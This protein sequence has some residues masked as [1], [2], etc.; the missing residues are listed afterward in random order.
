MRIRAGKV[1]VAIPESQ[2]EFLGFLRWSA[3]AGASVYSLTT[4]GAGRGGEM[5]YQNPSPAALPR[6]IER[7]PCGADIGDDVLLRRKRT[8][9]GERARRDGLGRRRRGQYAPRSATTA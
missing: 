8:Y 3:P 4:E 2:G 5:P 6:S 1:Y 9:G 7:S